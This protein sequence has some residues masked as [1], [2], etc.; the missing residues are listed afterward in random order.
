MLISGHV[1]FHQEGQGIV[2]PSQLSGL[3]YLSLVG[4]IGALDDGLADV[5]GKGLV[6]V[7]C[8]RQLT[9]YPF[10]CYFLVSVDS[11]I[12]VPRAFC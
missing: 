9:A 6:R 3:T 4:L 1:S 8:A 12:Y 11:V 5:P 7:C 10:L 2:Y